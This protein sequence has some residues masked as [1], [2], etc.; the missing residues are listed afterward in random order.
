MA[1]PRDDGEKWDKISRK[2][3]NI[4]QAGALWF[5]I[6]IHGENLIFLLLPL[7][8]TPI[9]KTLFYIFFLPNYFTFF[10]AKLKKKE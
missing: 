1:C 10:F 5:K 8:A 4:M 7:P 3:N 6:L 9:Q 2:S